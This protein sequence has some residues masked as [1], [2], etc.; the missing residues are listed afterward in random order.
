MAELNH[1]EMLNTLLAALEHDTRVDMHHYPVRA[2]VRDGALLLEGTMGDIAAKRV[3]ARIAHQIA[4]PLPVSDQL[5][6]AVTEPMQDGELRTEVTNLLLHEPAFAAYTVRMR[7]NGTPEV[8]HQGDDDQNCTIDI[9]INGG[10]VTLDGHVGSLSH[11][12][13]AEV[14]VWW[15]AGCELVKNQL[16]VV[17]PEQENDGEL[18]DA[19]RMVLEKDP[20]VHAG[21]LAVSARDGTVT[22]LGYVASSEERRL[23]VLDTWYVPGVH[24]VVDRIAARG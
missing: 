12:R 21:Q 4:A 11:R 2:C 6:L 20:L 24:E 8:L 1:A 17:P 18:T 10:I 14:L 3:A 22:L 7:R 19:I 16:R 23:A 15:A 5:R 9:E 13:L